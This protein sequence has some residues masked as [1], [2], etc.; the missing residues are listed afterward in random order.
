MS[1]ACRRLL[2]DEP[3]PAAL[4]VA[5]HPDDEVIGLG[6]QLPRLRARVVVAHLTDG[7][8]HDPGD[9]R[10]AGFVTR[11]AYARARRAELEAALAVAGIRPGRTR[12]LGLV[13]QE[14]SLH[15]ATAARFVVRLLAD[16]RPDLV[17][18]PAYEGGHPD[19]DAA[20]FAVHAAVRLAESTAPS[21]VEFPL[22]RAG[23]R[24]KTVASFPPG[25]PPTVEVRLDAARRRLKRRMLACFVSQQRVLAEFGLEVERF[26]PAPAHDFARPPH[27]GP[28]HYESQP[29]GLTGERWRELA[30]A[31]ERELGV[32]TAAAAR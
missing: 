27:E 1:D 17:V 2:R 3:V 10:A 22:Y 20:A 19:H 26:R 23:P 25:G 12:E 15:L 32:A 21:V 30:L 16:H 13:D 24:G 6:A 11:E 4:V 5:A 7:S 14:A 8:P 9:A 18:V 29:W 31:A 28:L